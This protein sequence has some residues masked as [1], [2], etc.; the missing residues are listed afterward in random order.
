M[1]KVKTPYYD[2]WKF[3]F[4][5]GLVYKGKEQNINYSMMWSE[6][7]N[8]FFFW[9]KQQDKEYLLKTDIITLR[10]KFYSGKSEYTCNKQ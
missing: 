8:E 3:M 1:A 7:H 10:N 9:L 2:F 5:Q 6:L 4:S